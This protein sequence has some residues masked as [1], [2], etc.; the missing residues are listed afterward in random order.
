[1]NILITGANGQL[2]Q[3]F[4]YIAKIN[5]Y[6]N[7]I[8]VDKEDLD[9]TSF[10]SLEK[11]FSIN[12][13]DAVINCAAYTAVDKAES[14]KELAF[15]I[16]VI[17]PQNLAIISKKYNAKLIHISTDYV[18]DGTNYVP[19]KESDLPNPQ[20]IYGR[21]KLDGEFEVISNADIF[22]IIRIS[23][24]YS[25]YGN[26]FVKNVSKLAREKKYLR[27]IFDQIGTPTYARDLASAILYIL[28]QLNKENSEIYHYSNEGV[29]SWYDLTKTICKLQ[30]ISCNIEPIETKDYPL[31][32]KRP[33]YSV[34]NKS[35]IKQTFNLTIPYWE[36][37]LESWL[38]ETN[39]I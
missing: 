26:N 30:N 39:K 29:T 32:A 8:F 18:F 2:G 13:I 12:K 20:S 1:M 16:N 21:T 11:F 24:L 23:W 14:E 5:T 6:H 22:A 4:R 25:I 10:L 34:F 15:L 27:F 36:D 17:G 9:I 38:E 37:S 19:Y 33:H 3:E 31:P 7:F 28:P 35:K